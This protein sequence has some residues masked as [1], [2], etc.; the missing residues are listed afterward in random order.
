[1]DDLTNYPK[2]EYVQIEGSDG[3]LEVVKINSVNLTDSTINVTLYLD[4]EDNSILSKMRFPRIVKDLAN[5]LAAIKAGTYYIGSTTDIASSFNVPD[6]SITKGSPYQHA[7]ENLEK[8]I[9]QRDFLL[10]QIVPWP[11]FA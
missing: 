3:N 2:N 9:A 8:N 11:S 7:K 10:K 6:Y 4:H 5:T 1:M